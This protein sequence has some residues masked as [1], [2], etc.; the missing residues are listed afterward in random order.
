MLNLS[1]WC[2]CKCVTRRNP[3]IQFFWRTLWSPILMNTLW[4][5]RLSKRFCKQ[6]SESSPYS[7][8]AAWQLQYWPNNQ[9][10]CQKNVYKTFYSTCRPMLYSYI[11]SYSFYSSVTVL[12]FG[13]S[14]VGSQSTGISACICISLNETCLPYPNIS[15]RN[16]TRGDDECLLLLVNHLHRF[17]SWAWNVSRL[18]HRY[19]APEKTREVTSFLKIFCLLS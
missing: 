8:W 16:Y 17:D 7:A 10:Y 1:A 6:I 9:C 11:T 3:G 14:I 2:N 19:T 12:K 5:G 18:K 4:G 15:L 13:M